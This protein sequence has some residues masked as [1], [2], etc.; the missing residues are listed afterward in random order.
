VF[1]SQANPK[2]AG[3]SK[4]T[5]KGKSKGGTNGTST[6]VGTVAEIP[7]E[8]WLARDFARISYTEAI[9]ALESSGA[10]FTCVL[11]ASVAVTEAT[12][13]WRACCSSVI[14]NILFLHLVLG[15]IVVDYSSGFR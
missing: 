9:T 7:D 10:A 12:S 4:G 11:C 15:R 5:G 3:T 2:A 1:Y 8:K 6:S 14:D 13:R